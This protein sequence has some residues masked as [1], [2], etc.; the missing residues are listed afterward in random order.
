MG[1]NSSGIGFIGSSSGGGAGGTP[2]LMVQTNL[3]SAE[4]LNIGT[5]PIQLVA[6]AGPNT[7]IVPQSIVMNYTFLSSPYSNTALEI[8]ETIVSENISS[9]SDLQNAGS[10][11]GYVY[12]SVHGRYLVNS[13]LMIGSGT[14][15]PTGGAGSILVTVYY[16]VAPK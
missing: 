15:N 8:F 6:A 12:P 4:I 9:F 11:I 10:I 16:I 3:T 2:L 13:P 7:I 5:T 14:G 1:F